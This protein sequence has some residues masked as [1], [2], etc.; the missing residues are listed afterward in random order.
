MTNQ[1]P[2][3]PLRSPPA[4]PGTRSSTITRRFEDVHLRTLFAE[5]PARGERFSAEAAR[6]LP[7][8]LEEPDHPTRRCSSCGRSPGR[9]V[10][11]PD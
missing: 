4:R 8:L 11:G 5:D 7:R 1:S 2:A 6:P 10:S 3:S 9:V